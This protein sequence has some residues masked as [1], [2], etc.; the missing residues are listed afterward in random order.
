[1][2]EQ[3]TSFNPA[4]LG[5]YLLQVREQADIK[6]ADLAKRVSLSPAVLSR[7]ETGDRPVTLEEVVDILK[8]IPTAGAAR[9]IEAVQRHWKV[10]PVPPL[11]H[12]DQDELWQA[13]QVA[14]E[15][16]E[17][18]SNPDLPQAFGRR[19]GE[20]ADELKRCAGLL[21]KRE[22][23]VAFIGAIGVGKSTAIGFMTDLTV[24]KDDG[25]LAPVL[26]DGAGGTT[27]CEVHLLSGP[28]YGIAIEPGTPDE[29]RE[30]VRDFAEHVLKGTGG[31]E[32]DDVRPGEPRATYKEVERAIRNMSGLMFKSSRDA[33]GK[34]QT[35]DPAKELAAECPTVRE[36]TVEVLTR[37]NLPTRDRR[38][39]WY[40]PS[41][42]KSPL[43]WLRDEF[44]RINDGKHP[45]F[46]LPKRI[47]VIVK[48]SLLQADGLSVRF[49][50]TKGIHGTAARE[51]LEV[52]LKDPHTL[53]VLCSHFNDAPGSPAQHLLS[54]AVES[55]IRGLEVN[56]SVL[57]LAHHDQALAVVDDATGSAVE[58]V[59]DG[60]DLKRDHALMN[61]APLGLKDYRI[62]FYNCLSDP[63]AIA[64]EF[65][66][67]GLQMARSSF[68]RQ[69]EAATRGARNLLENQR[70][71]ANQAAFDEAA[72][73]LQLWLRENSKVPVTP[74]SVQ[75]ELLSEILS[76]PA[77]S[78]AAAAR[79]DG[80]WRSFSYSYQLGFGA[81]KLCVSAVGRRVDGFAEYC[82]LLRATP[83][84]APA[85]ELVT[86]V[87]RVLI[88]GFDQMQNKAQLMAQTTYRE[89]L[90][91]AADLWQ[92]CV[93]EW[94][95]SRGYR[96]AVAMFSR[97]WF[98]DDKRVAMEGDVRTMLEREWTRTLESV[99]EL[100]GPGA[101][102]KASE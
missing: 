3:A 74:G 97:E 34:R 101:P 86:Q 47:E 88:A 77:S 21:L 78:V 56:S 79:R 50:D 96:Q 70:E 52:H 85:C 82:R 99:A 32:D 38:Q 59:E 1:M 18:R 91:S 40:E 12:V 5:R 75:E 25:K 20:Y 7:I 10:L 90:K 24:R 2:D 39:I 60:Y 48:K 68:R 44:R 13:E 100:L 14:R 33:A 84:L 16:E 11:D 76:A 15:L 9:L 31:A 6:Q 64:Q 73:R 69:L 29:I 57:V 49:I 17:L 23:Q 26:A 62:G 94:G 53:A 22:H 30:D 43:A 61:M 92:R 4:E 98:T 36:F 81:R 8:Q 41:S 65:L 55:G 27:L 89:A 46:T 28:Q 63:G 67:Q 72:A 80:E 71:Q 87:E 93:A 37:M 42:G 66:V 95:R 83:E 19:I 35:F 54:R 102:V 51:D 45:E 58:T